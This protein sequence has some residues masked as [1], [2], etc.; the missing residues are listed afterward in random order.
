VYALRGFAG[1]E[2]VRSWL[3]LAETYRSKKAGSGKY[4]V[5]FDTEKVRTWVIPILRRIEAGD[6]A[7]RIALVL[8]TNRQHVQYF[9]GKLEEAGLIYLEKRSSFAVYQL[10]LKGKAFLKSC[11]G[12]VFPGELHRLDKGQVAFRVVRE[13]VYPGRDFR[14][15]EMVNWTALLGLELGVKV[16]HT[17]KSW[18]VHVPVIRGRSPAEVYG[19]EMN[20]ANRVAVALC[21]KYGCVLAEGVPVGGEMAV[22]DPVAKMFGKY[23]AVR[24]SKRKIDHSWSEGELE[25]F[26]KDAVI[27]YLRM[28]EKVKNID[29]KLDRLIQRLAEALGGLA[30]VEGSERFSEGQRRLAEYVS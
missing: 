30:D 2:D 11:E 13:G 21:G 17:S 15:V 9:I 24:T 7:A 26:G 16:R 25:N 8:E 3:F 6:Y 5:Q 28:P 29:K 14:R 23:F 19:L 1:R 22:E 10:T 4:K 18:I 12:R 27:D 20:L